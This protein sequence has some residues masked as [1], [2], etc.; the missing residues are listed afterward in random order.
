MNTVKREASSRNKIAIVRFSSVSDKN[1]RE[2]F[3]SDDNDTFISVDS[4]AAQKF[5]KINVR[6][7]EE[8]EVSNRSAGGPRSVQF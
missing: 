2:T 8:A 3:D 1:R 6:W 4:N 5:R 7:V